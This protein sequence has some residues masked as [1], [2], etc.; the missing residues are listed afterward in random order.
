[1]KR[2]AVKITGSHAGLVC[3]TCIGL[4]TTED[5]QEAHL[6]TR[7][8]L[9]EKKLEHYNTNPQWYRGAEIVEVEVTGLS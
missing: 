8:D 6:Y 5:P 3:Y 2:Y 7:R 9:A 1:M 4:G